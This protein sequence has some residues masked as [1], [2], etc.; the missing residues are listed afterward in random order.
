MYGVESSLHKPNN[1]IQ[2]SELH[3]AIIAACMCRDKQY[4]QINPVNSIG[5]K[6]VLR[7][8]TSFQ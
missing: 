6:E 5:L 3:S 7:V 8:G 2:R 4:M 1:D